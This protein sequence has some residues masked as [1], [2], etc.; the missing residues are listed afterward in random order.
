MNHASDRAEIDETVQGLPAPSAEAADPSFGGRDC[1]RNEQNES[2]E[3]NGNEPAFCYVSEHL[4]EIKKFV[5][6]DIREEM[7][8]AVEEGE[9]TKHPAIAN[10]PKLTS[11]LSDWGDGKSD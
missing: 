10:Q 3:A 2:G 6:P 9:Q 4:V 5:Q 1:Q 11:Q 7:K 8:H